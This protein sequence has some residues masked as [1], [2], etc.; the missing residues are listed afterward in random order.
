MHVSI[1]NAVPG[2]NL[3]RV[4]SRA[5]Q[6]ISLSSFNVK[7]E[8]R[9]LCEELECAKPTAIGGGYGTRPTWCKRCE[10]TVEVASGRPQ[11]FHLAVVTI[12]ARVGE[13][14]A[15]LLRI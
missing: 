14:A 6:S 4:M 12:L 8:A 11:H 2:S 15:E 3:A 9:N 10:G 5:L 13:Q 1:Q 7:V